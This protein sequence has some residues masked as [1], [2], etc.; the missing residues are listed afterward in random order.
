MSEKIDTNYVVMIETNKI[1]EAGNCDNC[2]FHCN[3]YMSSMDKSLVLQMQSNRMIMFNQF[4][5]P[6]RAYIDLEEYKKWREEG[7]TYEE[8]AQIIDNRREGEDLQR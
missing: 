4:Y 2:E 6:I 8:T 3:Y 1:P 7:K 5:C